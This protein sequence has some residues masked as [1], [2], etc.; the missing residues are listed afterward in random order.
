MIQRFLKAN[1]YTLCPAY[2]YTVCQAAL[3]GGLILALGLFLAGCPQPTHNDSGEPSVFSAAPVLTL[4]AGETAGTLVYS[5]TAPEPAADSYDL[6]Y[7]E[8]FLTDPAQIKAGTRLAG[9]ASGGTI[10]G[11]SPGVIYSALLTAYKDDYETADTGIR[12]RTVPLDPAANGGTAYADFTTPPVLTLT[13]GTQ[14]GSLT[15]SWTASDPAAEFY[16]LYYVE[17]TVTETALVKAGTEL[18]WVTSGGTVTVSP[19]AVCSALIE[20][21]TSHYHPSDSAVAQVSTSALPALTT[22]GLTLTPGTAAGSLTFTLTAP[23]PEP[24]SYVVYWI[25]GTVTDPEVIKTEGSQQALAKT[26]TVYTKTGLTWGGTYSALLRAVK[27]GYI[28][29][30]SAVVQGKASVKVPALALAVGTNSLGYSWTDSEPAADSYDL[31]YTSGT[32]MS[33]EQVKGGTKLTAATS[34]GSLSSL[35]PGDTYSFLV[36]AN[37]PGFDN[38]V[39]SGVIWGTIESLTPGAQTNKT[40]SGVSLNFRYV[41]S[42]SFQYKSG[43]ANV[44]A[45]TKGYWLGETE[46][47]QELFQAVMGTN[48]SHFDGS[49]GKEVASGETQGKRP[50]ER[51]SYYAAITFCNKL[52][53]LDGKDPAYSVVGVDNWSALTYAD[54]PTANNTAWNNTGL[55]TAKNGY[56][57]PS[58]LE[59][60]WAAIGA[61]KTSQPNTTDYAK[62]FAGSD[63]ANSGDDYTWYN[64]IS[65]AK[66]HE[67]A[68]KSPNELGL[69][70]M[71]GNV[72]EL[73]TA[74]G[75]PAGALEDYIGTLNYA[76]SIFAGGDW[77]YSIYDGRFT[78]T[79][80]INKYDATDNTLVLR[81]L[82]P[83]Q[84]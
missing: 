60:M 13:A 24:D 7:A 16:T 8:G 67:V 44:A 57:L 1:G 81:V 36:S 34:G 51:V 2:R 78:A 58:Y 12:Y 64:T 20:A 71:S 54:I 25:P 68:K 19:G 63:G 26:Y 22:P 41:P 33:P 10:G 53:L 66:T 73:F 69:Y 61:D 17:G 48:P 45:I 9:A 4:A 77:K 14:P 23:S 42:G 50:V 47:T 37:I 46:V 32:G 55:D 3:A 65:A 30:E 11:L 18:P 74:R 76:Q 83:Q 80:S 5:W 59:W 56:R 82:S 52:S 6:Y 21:R 43:A 29:S 27:S 35:S 38:P 39:D 62:A 72:N 70:D 75:V 28:A 40:F 15:Y 49:A 79:D 31:Y 84:P